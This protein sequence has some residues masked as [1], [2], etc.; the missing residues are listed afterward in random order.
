MMIKT[1]VLY[2]AFL[3]ANLLFINRAIGWCCQRRYYTQAAQNTMLMVLSVA[4]FVAE[5]IV[6]AFGN[7]ILIGGLAKALFWLVGLF[8]I[9]IAFAPLMNGSFKA[10]AASVIAHCVFNIAG[11]VLLLLIFT[12]IGIV[13]LA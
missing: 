8:L 12:S 10:T 1:F 4:A 13:L 2:T 5:V 7:S 11:Y 9:F 3:I 6:Y